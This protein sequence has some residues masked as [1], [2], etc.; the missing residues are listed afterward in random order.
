M[1]KTYNVEA[2]LSFD[3][4]NMSCKDSPKSYDVLKFLKIQF[5]GIEKYITC[6]DVVDATE[7]SEED[8]FN[9]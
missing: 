9:G 1:S 5:P 3:I 8:K 7:L 4:K 6:V 2:D